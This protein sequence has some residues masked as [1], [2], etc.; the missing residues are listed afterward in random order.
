M[1]PGSSQ[2]MV[3]LHSAVC[4]HSC[5][6]FL[7]PLICYPDENKG[8]WQTMPHNA[9]NLSYLVFYRVVLLTLNLGTCCT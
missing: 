2:P 8:L 9:K 3:C 7:Q 4:Q 1:A 5:M 6:Y